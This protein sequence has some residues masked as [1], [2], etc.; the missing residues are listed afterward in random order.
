MEIEKASDC[1]DSL[2]ENPA[3]LFGD[4]ISNFQAWTEPEKYPLS[5]G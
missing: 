4:E 3:H 2:L 1:S 5:R